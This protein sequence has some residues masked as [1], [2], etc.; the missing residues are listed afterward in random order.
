MAQSKKL[1]KHVTIGPFLVELICAPH[2]IMYEVSEAQGT[3]VQKPPYKIYLDKEMIDRGGADAVNVVLHECMH[4]A[5]YQY[6]LKD[7]EEETVVNS[8]GNFMTELL[9]RSELKDWLRENMKGANGKAKKISVRVRHS[10]KGR[11]TT[12]ANGKTKKTRRSNNRG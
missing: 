3:F 2:D 4:V 5:Y 12:W 11:K 6:Q 7:K 9:C 1:P 8:F 10:Q